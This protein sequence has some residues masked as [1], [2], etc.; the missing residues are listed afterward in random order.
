[1]LL[2]G[3]FVLLST[4]T[5]GVNTT[6]INTTTMGLEMEAN[7]NALSYAQSMMDEIQTRAFDQVVTNGKRVF[8]DAAMTSTGSFGPGGTEVIS[9]VDS[10]RNGIFLSQTKFRNWWAEPALWIVPWLPWQRADTSP[11]SAS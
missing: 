1:M 7:L 3:A 6:I 9:G 5:L 8:T 4:L 11:S 10:S 2:I